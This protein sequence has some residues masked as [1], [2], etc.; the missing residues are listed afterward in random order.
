MTPSS[1]RAP[2]PSVRL[3][4]TLSY[5]GFLMVAGALLLVV[6]YVFLLRYVPDEVNTLGPYSP[7]RGDLERA[8]SRGP[9]RRSPSCWSSGSSAA[10]SSPAGCSHR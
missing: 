3:K 1:A 7:N 8:S 6:V 4:L 10:G 2:G 9:C 5:V